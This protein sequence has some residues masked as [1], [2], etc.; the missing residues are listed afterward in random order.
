MVYINSGYVTNLMVKHTI[1]CSAVR[2]PEK[3]T[4]YT[5]LVGL[6]NA[7]NYNAGGEVFLHFFMMAKVFIGANAVE[8]VFIFSFTEIVIA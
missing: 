2:M 1:F 3:L 7:K 8:V 4:V 5:T 6:L